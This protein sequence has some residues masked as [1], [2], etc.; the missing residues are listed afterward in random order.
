M[1]MNVAK[2]TFSENRETV[3]QFNLR[4][5]RFEPTSSPKKIPSSTEKPHLDFNR[6]YHKLPRIIQPN[7]C[8]AC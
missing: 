5:V 6:Y 2:K 3:F 7:L 1:L 4:N 8:K